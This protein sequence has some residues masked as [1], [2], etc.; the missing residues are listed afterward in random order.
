[1]NRAGEIV[2]IK[3]GELDAGEG[4]DRGLSRSEEVVDDNRNSC[5]N[6]YVV[7]E[8]RKLWRRGSGLLAPGHEAGDT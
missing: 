5:H 1:M 4:W 7:V 3:V 2:Q 8:K 6:R